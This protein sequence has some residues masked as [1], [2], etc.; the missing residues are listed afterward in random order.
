MSPRDLSPGTWAPRCHQPPQSHQM[1]RADYLQD[2][3]RV[4]VEVLSALLT[5][6][7]PKSTSS[8]SEHPRLWCRQGLCVLLRLRRGKKRWWWV[9][10]VVVER[11]QTLFY[12]ALNTWKTSYL[13]N[14]CW[15]TDRTTNTEMNKGAPNLHIILLYMCLSWYSSIIHIWDTQA[16]LSFCALPSCHQPIYKA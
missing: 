11:R 8:N 12:L 7:G 2:Q 14:V 13:L 10:L 9:V 5:I 1:S 4:R 15:M 3:R 16:C 6:C